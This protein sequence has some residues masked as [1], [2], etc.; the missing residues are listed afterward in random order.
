MYGTDSREWKVE[1]LLAGAYD[2]FVPDKWQREYTDDA[3]RQ[4][5]I[6]INKQ[7]DEE[8][9]Q[10]GIPGLDL[11]QGYRYTHDPNSLLI[12]KETLKRSGREQ[13]P[14]TLQEHNM[15]LKIRGLLNL[16]MDP[17]QQKGVMIQG[18]KILH[19]EGPDALCNYL[20]KYQQPDPKRPYQRS[21]SLRIGTV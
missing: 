1:S 2:E 7:G 10:L 20:K 17:D 14:A 16:A 8:T 9:E 4:L 6:P 21:G 18:L 13:G 19:D 11:A 12:N 3:Y 5:G 15:K